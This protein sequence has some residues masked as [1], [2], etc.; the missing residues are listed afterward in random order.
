MCV[1]EFL[2]HSHNYQQSRHRGRSAWISNSSA[3]RHSHTHTHTAYNICITII[4]IYYADLSPYEHHIYICVCRYSDIYW[5]SWT[6]QVKELYNISGLEIVAMAALID[7]GYTKNRFSRTINESAS[8][9]DSLMKAQLQIDAAMNWLSL[10]NHCIS[11]SA[12]YTFLLVECLTF[13]FLAILLSRL[14][15]SSKTAFLVYLILINNNT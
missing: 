12:A 11:C 15:Y 2:S 1:R 3:I 9:W 14:I 13:F 6:Y 5:C 4:F 7:F 10:E 8:I